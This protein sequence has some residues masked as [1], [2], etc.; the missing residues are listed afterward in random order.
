MSG[1]PPALFIPAL[2]GFCDGF[3]VLGLALGREF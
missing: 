1:R 3:D 2:R